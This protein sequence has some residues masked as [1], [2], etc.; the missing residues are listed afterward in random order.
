MDNAMRRIG[1][2]SGHFRVTRMAEPDAPTFNL[3]ELQRLLEHDN[4]DMRKRLKDFMDQP[5]F[6]PRYDVS[7]VEERE[8]ALARLLAI[9]Q[10]GFFSV[11]DFASNPLN[12]FAAHECA[13]FC[14]GATATKMTVQFNLFGGTVLKL[15]TRRHH[16]ALLSKIDSLDAIG[17]FALTELGFGN[18]A[19]EMQTTATFDRQTDEFVIHTTTTLAQKYWITN[20]AIHAKWAVVFAQM[21]IGS[22][23]YGVHG[24]LVR[25]RNEDMTI[26][27]GVRIEDMGHKMGLNGVDNG[28]LW[29]D[30]VRVQRSALLDAQSQVNERG[31]FTSSIARTRD[32]F[33]K[34]ADQ[35]LPGRLCI[36]SMLQGAAKVSLVIAFRYASTRLS[37]GP[38]GASDTPI[39]DYQLQQRALMPL[40]ASTICLNLCLNHVKDR[41]STSSGFDGKHVEPNVAKEVVVLCCAIKPLVTWNSERVGTTSRER[42]GG[43]G[44]LSCNR[45]GHTIVFAHAGMTAEGDNRVLMQ[46]VAKELLTMMS[47]PDV[48]R[49]LA[50]ASG[51]HPNLHAINSLTDCMDTGLLVQL[52]TIREGILLKELAQK[53]QSVD[54]ELAFEQWMKRESDLVQGVATAFAEREALEA[55]LKAV[56]QASYGLSRVL[57]KLAILYGLSRLEVDLAWFLS[58]EILLPAAGKAIPEAVRRLCVLLSPHSQVLVDSFGIPDHLVSAPIA[59]DWEAFNHVDNRGEVVGSFWK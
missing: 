10:R 56:D 38:K 11:R 52:F 25:I 32:R 48:T 43:Q 22:T 27:P 54:S 49:R 58:N 19:V 30:H 39:L 21:I 18:N 37:V 4:F 28:K 51:N 23:N 8:L 9:C 13:G 42:C 7:L 29:F 24:F 53:M 55:S 50:I 45:F 47:W 46:K 33:L 5:L 57:E 2:I 35:L 41:W 44:Y 15:G 31:D 20:S 16:D 3:S 12:I 1:N 34:V 14:D 59:G 26:C 17:C 6:V 36:A 40:L